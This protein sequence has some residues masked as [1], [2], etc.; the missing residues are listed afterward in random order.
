MP[1]D[2]PSEITI[3]LRAWRDGD[4]TALEKLTKID[5]VKIKL[6]HI[7]SRRIRGENP[8]HPLQTI[9]LIDEFFVKLLDGKPV[10]WNNSVHFY[11]VA[12]KIMRQILIDMSRSSIRIHETAQF[13]DPY[14][15]SDPDEPNAMS[16]E[17]RTVQRAIQKRDLE[18]A[19]IT[20]KRA[21]QILAIEKALSALAQLDPRQAE[22]AELY[23]FGEHPI[24]I[25][26][27]V[28][29]VVPRTVRRDLDA[30]RAFIYRE[31]NKEQK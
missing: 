24:E 16:K 9:E 11:A 26:A 23:Y 1:S 31:V 8:G 28:K 3:L 15:F 19:K 30:A 29:G 10:E 25:I 27:K 4:E 6:R 18:E 2:S 5:E 12:S 13:S 17:E 7:A 22:I 21:F 20:E 14:R